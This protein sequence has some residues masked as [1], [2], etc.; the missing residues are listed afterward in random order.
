MCIFAHTCANAPKLCQR[1]QEGGR[2]S[3]MGSDL[4]KH[5]PVHRYAPAKVQKCTKSAQ[6]AKC[7]CVPRSTKNNTHKPHVCC[8]RPTSA[9]CT[10]W[11]QL[12]GSFPHNAGKSKWRY[13]PLFCPCSPPPTCPVP[14]TFLHT[15]SPNPTAPMPVLTLTR[16]APLESTKNPITQHLPGVG[17]TAVP[18]VT[19]PG[20]GVSVGAGGGDE[21]F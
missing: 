16:R 12:L 3:K 4:T 5:F 8:G 20:G 11:T 7:T 17:Q 1:K 9:P 21:R 18:A 19:D 15:C 2:A 6:I 10:S 13:L 14:P